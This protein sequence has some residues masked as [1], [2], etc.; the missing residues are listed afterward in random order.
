ML[1][2]QI[3]GSRCYRSS[4]PFYN[5]A[6]FSDSPILRSSDQCLTT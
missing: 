2:G 3:D 4:T 6:S 1:G 5:A